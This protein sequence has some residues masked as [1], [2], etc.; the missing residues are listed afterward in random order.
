M[1]ILIF[2][3]SKNVDRFLQ[4]FGAETL[5]KLVYCKYDGYYYLHATQLITTCISCR[6]ESMGAD[7]WSYAD[8]LPYFMKSESHDDPELVKAGTKCN[9][10]LTYAYKCIN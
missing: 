1:N 3:I 7:G 10:L 2:V 9:V 8:V 5:S 4:G 6:W